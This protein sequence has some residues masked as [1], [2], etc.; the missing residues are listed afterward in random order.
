MSQAGKGAAL[1]DADDNLQKQNWKRCKKLEGND[2]DEKDTLEHCQGQYD[3]LPVPRDGHCLFHCFI[4]ILE[5]RL[6]EGPRTVDD[7]R[8]AIGEH[9][10]QMGGLV[11]AP[12]TPRVRSAEYDPR[13]G[14][15]GQMEDILAFA[16]KYKIPIVVHTPEINQAPQLLDY[17]RSGAP[18]ELLLYTQSWQNGFRTYAG[19]HWQRLREKSSSSSPSSSSLQRSSNRSVSSSSVVDCSGRIKHAAPSSLK[20]RSSKSKEKE[21][22][23]PFPQIL[24]KLESLADSSP[25]FRDF[26]MEQSMICQL[27]S[28]ITEER[29]HLASL[30]KELSGPFRTSCLTVAAMVELYQPDC[31]SNE[32]SLFLSHILPHLVFLF[33]LQMLPATIRLETKSNNLH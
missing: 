7:M 11:Y 12:N 14:D 26:L 1:K 33:S 24:E 21:Q 32:L 9:V 25:I 18:P 3:V 13:K 8:R 17:E 2:P 15:Y 29:A 28:K 27:H 16:E 22:T 4:Q 10:D 6:V 23:V 19:D 30:N 5:E 31:S 20:G